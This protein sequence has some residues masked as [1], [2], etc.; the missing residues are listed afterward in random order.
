MR[1]YLTDLAERVLV[2]FLGAFGAALLAAGPM[3]L[4]SLSVW[5]SAALGGVA[6]VVALLKGLF[7]QLV[8]DRKSASLTKSI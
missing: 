2:T 6:A 3:N 4:G 1:K 8:G 5:Q 7:A